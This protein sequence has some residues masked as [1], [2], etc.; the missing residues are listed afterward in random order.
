MDY[1]DYYK[2]LGVS[3]DATADQITKAYK[4]LA[5]KYH[6]DLNKDSDAEGRFKEVNEAYEVLK[7]PDKR[8]RYDT[9]GSNWKHGV[10]FEP[11]F[12]WSPG[13]PGG[14]HFDF[15][16][17]GGGGGFGAGGFSDFF[18][19]LFGGGGLGDL[20]NPTQR[21]GR[22]RP[23]A[24]QT[25]QRRGQDVETEL[26]VTIEDA[27]SGGTRSIE[28]SGANG[29]R[30][31]DVKIP[32]GIRSGER[33]RL[34]N[35]GMPGMGGQPGDLYITVRVAPHS[36]FRREGDDLIVRLDIPAWDAALGVKAAVPTLGGD[37]QMTLPPGLSSG[38]KLRLREK[39]MP[40]KE[41]GHGDLYAELNVTVPP[42]LTPE[43]KELF[44]QLREASR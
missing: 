4:R 22:G 10:P 36:V 34:A 30:R 33:L 42:K 37:V 41:G 11:P 13:G 16:P 1:I 28:L 26:T 7:D 12:G 21:N 44:E 29:A 14:V 39:G 17:G 40:R 35:Q 2:I 31:Y 23:R 6:P 25:T 43:Q 32:K 5:R 24:R 9:L 18:E 19:T 38:Q 15:R 20:F 8:Q 27:F 3:R